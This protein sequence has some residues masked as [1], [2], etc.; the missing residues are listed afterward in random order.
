M[1]CLFLLDGGE[2]RENGGEGINN[3]TLK[4]G[5][6][7]WVVVVIDFFKLFWM[8][9]VKLNL[10]RISTKFNKSVI[11]IIFLS[12]CMK[13][14][15]VT[16]IILCLEIPSSTFTHVVGISDVSGFTVDWGM[17]V[18]LVSSRYSL[19]L[20]YTMALYYKFRFR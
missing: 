15:E 20:C 17:C 1:L 11:F 6:R 7:V 4:M 19:S 8:G 10:L 9:Q 16:I 14:T 2:V 18:Q 13:F 5:P 12:H 3:H